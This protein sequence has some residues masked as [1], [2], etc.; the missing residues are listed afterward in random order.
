MLLPGDFGMTGPDLGKRAAAILT[1][2]D[3]LAMLAFAVARICSDPELPSEPHT[4]PCAMDVVQ[5]GFP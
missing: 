5:K 2:L 3:W 1:L 4:G